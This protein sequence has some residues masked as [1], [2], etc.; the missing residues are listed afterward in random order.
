MAIEK[1]TW[2]IWLLGQD[3][4]I[5]DVVLRRRLLR[6]CA[7]YGT[8]HV[9]VGRASEGYVEALTHSIDC[10]VYRD[11]MAWYRSA[12]RAA[13][14]S[15]FGFAF[16]PGEVRANAQIGKWYLKLAPLL[17]LARVRG[18]RILSFGLGLKPE[19]SKWLAVLKAVT[20]TAHTVAWRDELSPTL[21]G[22]GTIQPDLAFDETL[23]VDGAAAKDTVALTFRGDRPPPSNDVLDAIK[24][25]AD[26]QGLQLRLFAQVRSDAALAEELAQ[27]LGVECIGWSA[28][29]NHL[30]QEIRCRVLFER[31]T[32]V[33][34]DRLHALIM[35]STHNALPIG[36]TGVTD[37]KL[38]RH[39]NVVG[40]TANVIETAETESAAIKSLI[41]QRQ[42]E[43]ASIA[44]LLRVARQRV[45]TLDMLV[46]GTHGIN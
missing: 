10:V 8:A 43:A 21:A 25:F 15:D 11:S 2:F 35:A 4:N 1:R 40:L 41:A 31:S 17:A 36:L 20:K 42:D 19:S 26:S 46:Q 28:N 24:G 3:D 34:S 39:L 38:A 18:G 16:N 13:T 33:I 6:A 5:G 45:R 44:E 22:F 27:E 23:A 37:E 32:V 30:E 12:M 9:Y 29:L 7:R 14:R